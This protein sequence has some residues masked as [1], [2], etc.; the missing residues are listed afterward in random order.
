[1]VRSKCEGEGRQRVENKEGQ[2]PRHESHDCALALTALLYCDH[3]SA[4]LMARL[5][6]PFEIIHHAGLS[7]QA[8]TI[9]LCDH[10]AFGGSVVGISAL[11]AGSYS[12][13]H[14]ENYILR[15]LN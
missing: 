11:R 7:M 1:V 3:S 10:T 12:H 8:N 5:A 15:L 6:S 9:W 4:A 14:F 13:A 2:A